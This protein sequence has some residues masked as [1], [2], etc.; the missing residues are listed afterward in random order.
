ME[1]VAI[2]AATS[3]ISLLMIFAWVYVRIEQHKIQYHNPKR[4]EELELEL[5]RQASIVNKLDE[6]GL[7]IVQKKATEIAGHLKDINVSRMLGR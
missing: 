7:D 3:V 1:I 2:C 6:E 4:I 5:K